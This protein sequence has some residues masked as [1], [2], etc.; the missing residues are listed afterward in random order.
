MP[1]FDRERDGGPDGFT[2]STTE[3]QY[4]PDVPLRP[5][6]MDI[7]LDVDLTQR[8]A[9]ARLRLQVTASAKART[10]RLDAVGLDIRSVAGTPALT[11]R[12][13]GRH[14]TITFEEA[15]TPGAQAE[16]DIQYTIDRPITGMQFSTPDPSYPNRPLLVA[17]DHETERARYWLPCIDHPTVRST[18]ALH[19]TVPDDL[20]VVAGGSC[21]KEEPASLG[22]KTSHWRLDYPCP[23]YLFC[24]AAGELVTYEDE[25]VDGLSIAYH[26]PKG[27]DPRDLAR[28][29]D[30]TPAMVRWLQEH[31]G[32][33]LPFPKY[34]QIAVP[35]IGGAM[36]NISLVT[37]DAQFV[38]DQTLAKEWAHLDDIINLH[39]MAHS[40]F[41]DAIVIRH[42]DH[43]WLKESWATYLEV[44]WLEDVRGREERDYELIL[45]RQGYF[46]ETK[47]YVRPIVT[48][49]YDSSWMMFDRHLYPGG[50]W[51]LHML[52][53]LLGN[54]VFWTAVRDYVARYQGEVVETD[55][56]RRVLEQHSSRDLVRFFDQWIYGRGYPKLK[57]TFQYDAEAGLVTLRL[58]QT[59]V[60][61]DRQIGLF[62]LA[63]DIEVED[64]QGIRRGRVAF[65]GAHGSLAIPVQG[66]PRQV[67]IDPELTTLFELE[68]DPGEDIL[69][70]TLTQ[71]P[72]L[73]NRL[74]A[75][76]TLIR[77]GTSSAWTRLARAL[78][79]EPFHG[80]RAQLAKSLAE[81]RRGEAVD[82]L[83]EVLLRETEP[84][85]LEPIAA[86]CGELRD[87][88]LAEALRSWL[89]R[90]DLPYRGHARAL[91]SLGAQRD[92]R[93]LPRLIAA[94]DDPG[95]GGLVRS[96]ALAGLG[97]HRS[98]QA[99]EQLSTRL[100][101]GAER[102]ECRVAAI[103]G[104]ARAAEWQP[105]ELRKQAR[106]ALVDLLRDPTEKVRRT[107]IDG[108]VL[109]G[110]T[111]AKA[112]VEATESS[113]AAQWAPWVR[114]RV[115]KLATSGDGA[116]SEKLRSQI[117]K[118]EKR[119]A[120]LESHQRDEAAEEAAR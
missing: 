32:A 48:R 17:T 53:G 69:E 91:E 103:V 117:E 94:A 118:L 24:F 8:R 35:D 20:V 106:E 70:R 89:D 79:T 67:R 75:G 16:V 80:V 74:W 30:R 81:S 109:L 14:L 87:E 115:Q 86:A 111:E 66:A 99:F 10:L 102:W 47:E 54:E 27:T 22:R 13:D 38:L 101:Y 23:A 52:R 72:D 3:P 34:H 9:E 1:C 19:L 44:A 33:K 98:R 96:G 71:A 39:E 15:L 18:F 25:S 104:F 55:D 26:A 46:A 57:G 112:A 60:D 11:S 29:F 100:A 85:A 119:V 77:A 45:E 4:A 105:E 95:F 6:H 113:F 42:F 93:D 49:H 90:K 59:Q 40:Y 107:A 97:H 120:D 73:A 78:A 76:R 62:D 64:E 84:R 2:S 65:E 108:L 61:A 7:A 92:L 37:W 114:R 28:S 36:E 82:I 31:L 5:T 12:S 56:F 41:G 58:E 50:S 51:R 116:A 21:E 83:A 88:R 110:A 43:A 68:L 63:L